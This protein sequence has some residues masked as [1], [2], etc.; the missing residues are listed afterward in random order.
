MFG[1]NQ[2]NPKGFK[3]T[4][5]FDITRFFKIWFS[6]DPAQFLGIENE[7]RFIRMRDKNPNQRVFFVYSSKCLYAD[8]LNNLKLFCRRYRITPLDFDTEIPFLLTDKHDKE[9]Y[10]LAKLEIKNTL[11]DNEGNLGAAADCTR[12]LAP[13]IEKCGI[14]TDFDVECHLS[15]IQVDRVIIKAPILFNA[16]IML[17]P[18]K[19]AL[20]FNSDFLAY[21][22]NPG[23]TNLCSEALLAIRYVQKEI[24]KNYKT[25]LN[26]KALSKYQLEKKIIEIMANYIKDHPTSNVFEFR[27]FVKE[28]RLPNISA[29]N[30]ANIKHKL[31]I[32]SVAA[33][34]GP[35]AY[36]AIYKQLFPKGESELPTAINTNAAEWRPY[37]DLY[38]KS[39]V[40]F[41]DPI[42]DALKCRNNHTGEIAAML[43]A[44]TKPKAKKN[45]SDY[46]ASLS[47]SS[48]TPR[49]EQWKKLREEKIVKFAEAMQAAWRKKH[50]KSHFFLIKHYKTR[51]TYDE[52]SF[53]LK[54]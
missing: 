12:L 53:K 4:Y 13:I 27:K 43:D 41:Y 1:S 19:S 38:R 45:I 22:S 54:K 51:P 26:L 25:P 10:D 9:L 37:L 8:A 15:D 11:E 14:Y 21:A 36:Q 24:I 52:N 3:P 48:W 50:N 31:L 40:S 16:E 17:F 6:K 44:L 46:A 34:S 32:A 47:D 5:E 42:A 49:G 28:L 2:H 18:Q 29:S 20:S 30:L 23:T 7:L 33:I 35:H 39:S